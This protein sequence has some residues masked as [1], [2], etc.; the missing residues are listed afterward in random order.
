MEVEFN[1][2]RLER[3]YD[4]IA[5]ATREWGP[6]V[7]RSYIDKINR[8]YAMDTF[9]D[10]YQHRGLR[11]HALH[12]EYAGKFAITLTGRYRLIIGRGHSEDQVVI[13]E[14]TNHYDD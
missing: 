4:S 8:I 11:L 3:R 5:A 2:N 10:L 14:V 9:S 7:A 1:T 13:Y 12:G 6:A